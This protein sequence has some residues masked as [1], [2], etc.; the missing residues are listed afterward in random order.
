MLLPA[1]A[2]LHLTGGFQQLRDVGVRRE[3]LLQ[4]RQQQNAFLTPAASQESS[5]LSQTLQSPLIRLILMD[6]LQ[7]EGK[8]VVIGELFLDLDDQGGAF[9]VPASHEQTARFFQTLT[10]D[11]FGLLFA[12]GFQ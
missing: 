1:L 7:E 12:R 11:L 8:F 2:N 9:L 10:S 3:F 4:A 5:R 6:L